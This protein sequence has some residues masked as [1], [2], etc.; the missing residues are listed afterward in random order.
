M[1]CSF[2]SGGVSM[3]RDGVMLLDG[4]YKILARDAIEFICMY[5]CMYV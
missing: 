2:L 3:M 5:V 4:T 1:L